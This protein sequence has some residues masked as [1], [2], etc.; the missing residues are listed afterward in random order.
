MDPETRFPPVPPDGPD[1]PLPSSFDGRAGGCRFD[2]AEMAALTTCTSGGFIPQARHGGRGVR[3]F[4]VDGSK[5][6]GTGLEKEHMGHT[7]VAL[8]GGADAGAGLPLPSGVGGAL[9][10][11]GGPC[12]SRFDGLGKSVTLPEDLRKPAWRS[13]ILAVTSP[14]ACV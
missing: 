6:D 13:Q 5:L 10:V 2:M 11:L 12:D 7:Q 9:L 8:S 14:G 4:A 1:V 3:A